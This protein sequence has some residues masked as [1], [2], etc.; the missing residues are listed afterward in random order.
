MNREESLATV[1]ASLRWELKMLSPLNHKSVKGEAHGFLQAMLYLA[2]ATEAGG[3][4]VCPHSTPA[5]QEGCLFTAGRRKAPRVRDARIRRW[6]AHGPPQS[7][8]R[9]HRDREARGMTKPDK[10]KSM[11]G[12]ASMDPERRREIA[13]R[14][15]AAV[16]PENRTFAR[17]REA[18]AAAG[19]KGGQRSKGGG[20]TKRTKEP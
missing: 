4:T 8:S 15:G 18:A 11:R 7:D 2:P 1:A 3:K 5:C 10:P 9:T 12:F 19:Q 6:L 13:A 20:R 17:D 16:L 14:G